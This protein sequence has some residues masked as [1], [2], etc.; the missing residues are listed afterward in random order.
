LFE[1]GDWQLLSTEKK[2]LVDSD[3]V[4]RRL[5]ADDAVCG[6]LDG[7]TKHSRLLQ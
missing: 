3:G 1:G 5:S 6:S 2:D 7:V 4:V